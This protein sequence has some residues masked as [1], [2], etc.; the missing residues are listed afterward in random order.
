MINLNRNSGVI[1]KCC[2]ILGL[3]SLANLASATQ[4]SV[5][6][7]GAK[8]D[9]TLIA[10]TDYPGNSIRR[11]METLS[12]GYPNGTEVDLDHEFCTTQEC[13]QSTAQVSEGLTDN[14]VTNFVNIPP[15]CG[16]EIYASL[17]DNVKLKAFA[18]DLTRPEQDP[19]WLGS[20]VIDAGNHTQA[21]QHIGNDKYYLD[22]NNQHKYYEILGL[23]DNIAVMCLPLFTS[24]HQ[25]LLS[26]DR[27]AYIYGIPGA[28]NNTKCTTPDMTETTDCM[29]DFTNPRI[30]HA[31]V[32]FLDGK[33][34]NLE[35]IDF[36]DIG[37]LTPELF[38]EHLNVIEDVFSHYPR[39]GVGFWKESDHNFRNFQGF[40]IPETLNGKPVTQIDAFY[41]LN[42]EGT[43]VTLPHFIEATGGLGDSENSVEREVLSLYESA[44]ELNDWSESIQIGGISIRIS[45]HNVKRVDAEGNDIP[46]SFSSYENAEALQAYL[47][48]QGADF[49]PGIEREVL[50]LYESAQELNDW[51]ESIQIGGISI[52]I[53][54]HNVKK[55][56]AQGND[57]PGTFS[58]YANVE[59]LQAYLIEQGADFNPVESSIDSVICENEIMELYNLAQSTLEWSEV[60][61]VGGVSVRVSKYNIK[62][63]DAQ[64]YDVPNSQVSYE[65]IRQFQ[66][67]FRQQQA[68]C[69]TGIPNKVSAASWLALKS[70]ALFAAVSAHFFT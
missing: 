3:A 60:R 4:Y 51:S 61:S 12:A 36:Y 45:Q 40:T 33:Y 19:R 27:D 39:L 59:E 64:G 70:S 55:V 8:G 63:V 49:N 37:K 14:G 17:P 5:A 38:G 52:R 43:S 1:K 23:D 47:I 34:P 20:P 62:R 2:A 21:V 69:S 42:S 32:S 67:Y 24:H 28:D 7:G 68:D 30:L 57:I 31:Y 22:L 16:A 25:S 41:R 11:I 29:V 18:Y 15:M 58:Q 13:I 26:I 66:N 53:S 50:S 48:E 9:D 65:S 6:F 44:Q 10:I 35:R 54:Q 46:G 56:D